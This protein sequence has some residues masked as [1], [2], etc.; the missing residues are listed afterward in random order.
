MLLRF[1]V[2]LAFLTAPCAL[3]A[4]DRPNLVFILADDLGW[5]D[6]T[7]YGTTAFYETPN[8]ERLAKRGM[9]F[10]NA[11]TAHPLCSPTRCSIMTGF[12]PARSILFSS[13]CETIPRCS[14]AE[15][16]FLSA[17]TE[18][19]AIPGVT[20]FQI[21]RQVSSKNSHTFGISMKFDSDSEFQ[22]YCSHPL[23]NEFVESRWIPEVEEFQEADFENI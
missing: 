7:L 13:Q 23:H 18:L 1:A 21:R 14:S 12:D 4:A 15:S 5:S 16:D 2:F 3:M 20:D 19:A 8:I 11:Y 22:A 9:L 10:T 6:T 17:A